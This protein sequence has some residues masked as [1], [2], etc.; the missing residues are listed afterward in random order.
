MMDVYLSTRREL[1]LKE[2]SFKKVKVPVQ[3]PV[4]SSI[5]AKM[6]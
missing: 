2:V 5:G 1:A 4:K 6:T 3:L